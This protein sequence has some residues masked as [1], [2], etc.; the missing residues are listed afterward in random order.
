MKKAYELLKKFSASKIAAGLGVF[1]F[2]Y[3]IR[4]TGAA[5]VCPFC[6]GTGFHPWE[7]GGFSGI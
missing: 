4:G 1:A 6:G 2:V 7:W 5:G 3:M